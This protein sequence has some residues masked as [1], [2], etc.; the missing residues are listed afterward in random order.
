MARSRP[1]FPPMSRSVWE[2][3][4]HRGGAA[5]DGVR[6]A[7][8]G[9]RRGRHLSGHH[10]PIEWTRIAVAAYK[11]HGADRIVAEVNNGGEM[12]EATLRVVDDNVA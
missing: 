12:V 4:A 7:R 8:P 2:P 5:A 10:T 11:S 6:D 9:A 1:P 3:S